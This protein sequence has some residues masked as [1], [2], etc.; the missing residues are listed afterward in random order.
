[1]KDLQVTHPFFGCLG[2]RE[3]CLGVLPCATKF[4][5]FSPLIPSSGHDLNSPNYMSVTAKNGSWK[6]NEII[7]KASQ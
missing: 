2:C 3:S 6:G 5:F 4:D 1:M 7:R